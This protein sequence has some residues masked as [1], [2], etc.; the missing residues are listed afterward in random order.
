M[1]VK[2]KANKMLMERRVM[3]NHERRDGR[4]MAMMEPSKSD[5]DAK[6]LR[7]VECGE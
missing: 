7:D 2:A 6:T 1:T 3:G 5:A 4:L